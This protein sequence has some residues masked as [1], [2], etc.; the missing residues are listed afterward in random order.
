M[1]TVSNTGSQSHLMEIIGNLNTFSSSSNAEQFRVEIV[2][3]ELSEEQKTWLAQRKSEADAA[4][5]EAA[6][7]AATQTYESNT[8]TL[9][10]ISGLSLD[11]ATTLQGIVESMIEGNEDEGLTV[12]GAYENT[13]IDSLDE[14]LDYLNKYIDTIDGDSSETT[15][16]TS[17]TGSPSPTDTSSP[18]EDDTEET[19][20]V[21]GAD[22][23]WVDPVGLPGQD[24]VYL[25]NVASLSSE[26]AASVYQ[27][28][29]YLTQAV[30]ISNSVIHA[31]N[32]EAGT[33]S[34]D[35]YMSW[36]A[37]QAGTD[38]VA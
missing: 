25:P 27:Q 17:E 7:P 36:L 24:H 21:E 35:T 14:Y 19:T 37:D 22:E 15:S 12:S 26:K 1:S 11:T 38:L 34:I 5:A 32:G 16:P 31:R 2:P 20:T 33:Y 13:H 6:K 28:V 29:Q 8:I 3:V 23:N 30:D 4:I 10:N 18:T 9:D